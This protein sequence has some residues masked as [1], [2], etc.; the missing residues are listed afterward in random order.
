M[1]QMKL[2]KLLLALP[3][4]LVAC[5]GPTDESA[6]NATAES[7]DTT[8][9][10]TETLD[11]V[12]PLGEPEVEQIEVLEV[13]ENVAQLYPKFRTDLPLPFVP[14]AW[15]EDWEE[16]GEFH[17]LYTPE[18]EFLTQHL[19]A[20]DFNEA[21]DW[22]L[23]GFYKMDSIHRQGSYDD[24]MVGV[25]LGMLVHS[26]AAA[27]YRF[28]LDENRTVL[29]WGINYSSYEACPYYAG[30]LCF[31]TVVTNGEVTG[32]T[33]LNE[34]SGGGDPPV[35]SERKMHGMLTA[36]GTMGL[37]QVELSG[38]EDF[39]GEET[40]TGDS[41]DYVLSISPEG[42]IVREE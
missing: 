26:E 10:V 5:G 31:A 32:C 6:N 22:D 27:L 19:L 20:T 33:L 21:L 23:D 15:E 3:L 30:S 8:A 2:N 34:N 16:Q 36:N 4:A 1:L 38:E 12:V 29:T 9:E 11:T 40:I 17:P 42:L 7:E 28:D 37:H 41:T 39:E 18:V 35:W 24:Y 14:A 13:V 25:D